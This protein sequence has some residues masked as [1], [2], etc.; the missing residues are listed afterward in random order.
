VS[1]EDDFDITK[2]GAG[3]PCYVRKVKNTVCCGD[4]KRDA[5]ATRAAMIQKN[6]LSEDGGISSFFYVTNTLDVIR[7]VMAINY[8]RT[9]RDRVED[10]CLLAF[11]VDELEG[12]HKD[13]TEDQFVCYWAKKHHIDVTLVGHEEGIANI[14][15]H[16]NRLPKKFTNK[17]MKDAQVKMAA[18]GC[19]SVIQ[20]AQCVCQITTPAAK[21]P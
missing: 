4:P 20:A 5:E 17:K 18:D 9:G 12:T 15:A 2:L 1:V 19:Q 21:Q 3:A 13:Q 16:R 11:A 14:L 8:E 6:V 7:T 10:L